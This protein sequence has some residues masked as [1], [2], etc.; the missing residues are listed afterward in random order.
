MRM[1]T[2]MQET[3]HI[4]WLTCFKSVICKKSGNV[5]NLCR[6]IHIKSRLSGDVK[7]VLV[8]ISEI[9][10]IK[11]IRYNFSAVHSPHK[12]IF[13]EES[14]KVFQNIMRHC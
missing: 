6:N 10:S 8:I 4:W 9:I 5:N 7:N 11:T 12:V 3:G 2:W 14:K 13:C 1:Y